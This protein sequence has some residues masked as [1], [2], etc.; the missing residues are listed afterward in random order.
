MSEMKTTGSLVASELIDRSPSLFVT[1]VTQIR[2]IFGSVFAVCFTILMS[3]VVI[4]AGF[5]GPTSFVT[6]LM[7]F[8]ARVVLF[9]FGIRLDV[10]GAEH[11][12]KKGGGIII[13]N[14]QSNLDIPAL[15]LSNK[16]DTRFGAKIELFK[17]PFFGAAMRAVGTLPIARSNRT[18]V[19]RIYQEASSRFAKNTIFVLAP[20]GTRQ[21]E[22]IIGRFKTGPF[23]FA[24]NAQ[25]PLIPAVIK[26]AYHVQHKG[27]LG[28]N[29]GRWTRTVVIEY[30]PPIPTEGLAL[31]QV[32]A[33][34]DRSRDQII[35]VYDRL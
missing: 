33:L 32:G 27:Q 20:E 9:V 7:R 5:V 35:E 10:R 22:P 21:S 1:I 17:I 4:L 19:L 13:F 30:L 8:W 11:L 6:R 25:V 3:V 16:L 34:M 12:P 14:H 15:M 18:E 26:G 29:V 23:H 28:V 2:S 31:D 24:I